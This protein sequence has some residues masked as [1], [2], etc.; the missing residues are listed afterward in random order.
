MRRSLLQG[1]VCRKLLLN[2]SQLLLGN[3]RNFQ[4]GIAV[5]QLDRLIRH[6]TVQPALQIAADRLQAPAT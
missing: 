4:Q 5:F 2:F 3:T 6:V 1:S